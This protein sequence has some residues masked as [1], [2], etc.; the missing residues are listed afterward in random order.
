MGCSLT[1]EPLFATLDQRVDALLFAT[2]RPI[3][4]EDIAKLLP[5]GADVVGAI[6]R[7]EARRRGRGVE[8]IKEA[9]GYMMRARQ[10]L[11]PGDERLGGGRKLSEQAVATLAVIAMHQPVTLR[12]IETVR[13]VKIGRA[14]VDG[15]IGSGLV[16]VVGHRRGTGQAAAYG[17][18]TRFLERTGLAALSDLPTPEEAFALDIS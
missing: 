11:L 3:K 12:Q 2:V 8:V 13:G 14:V 6:A 17:V 5:E 4:P 1:M 9:S 10:D 7:V 15:L 16:E 18:T